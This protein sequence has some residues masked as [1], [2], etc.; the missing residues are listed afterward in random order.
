MSVGK[1]AIT[2]FSTTIVHYSPAGGLTETPKDA[3]AW[4]ILNLIYKIYRYFF[5]AVTEVR[6]VH[7]R[8]RNGVVG[9]CVPLLAGIIVESPF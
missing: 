3:S 2:D 1:Y 8:I 7:I 6:H 4:K 5:T 9:V